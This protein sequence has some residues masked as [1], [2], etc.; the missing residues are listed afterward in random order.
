MMQRLRE[1]I[2]KT[3]H[4]LFALKK[5]KR[6]SRRV[7]GLVTNQLAKHRILANLA[8]PLVCQL[9][10]HPTMQLP[11]HTNRVLFVMQGRCMMRYYKAWIVHSCWSSQLHYHNVQCM[12]CIQ[13]RVWGCVWGWMWAR[14]KMCVQWHANTGYAATGS[15][16]CCWRLAW[17][18]KPLHTQNQAGWR[19]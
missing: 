8:N 16:C 2:G 11:F 1:H 14:V 9:P 7:C 13:V 3:P 17:C 4:G 6:T 19:H 15:A 10:C 18:W 12:W 5:W